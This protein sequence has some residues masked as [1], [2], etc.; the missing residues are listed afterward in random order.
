MVIT[1]VIF[2]VYSYVPFNQRLKHSSI[3]Y[4]TNFRQQQIEYFIDGYFLE[5]MLFGGGILF[6]FI[7]YFAL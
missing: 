1:D 2:L 6:L 5:K 4:I 3:S 7:Y